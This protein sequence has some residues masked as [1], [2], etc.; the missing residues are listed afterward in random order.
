MVSPLF[1]GLFSRVIGVGLLVGAVFLAGAPLAALL[2][3]ALKIGWYNP[4][5]VKEA[6]CPVFSGAET[7]RIRGLSREALAHY[8]EM[9]LEFP[10]EAE[11]YARMLEILFEDLCE[12]RRAGE[13]MREGIQVLT[14]VASRSQLREKYNALT[15]EYVTS[16]L[17]PEPEVFELQ[18]CTPIRINQVELTG[19]YQ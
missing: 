10:Q 15:Q 19:S 4:G 17:Q 13:I 3:V 14:M 12:P 7:L 18:Y 8:E 5:V 9:L 1:G 2:L 16:R 11:V 6:V